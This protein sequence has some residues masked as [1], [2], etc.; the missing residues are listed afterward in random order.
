MCLLVNPATDLVVLEGDS[1]HGSP[2][3]FLALAVLPLFQSIDL[4]LDAHRV[5]AI[6]LILAILVAQLCLERVGTPA[7]AN[8][9]TSA[10][11]SATLPIV[12]IVGR[13][14]PHIATPTLRMGGRRD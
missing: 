11:P 7:R 3:A 14:V 13:R 6:Y 10:I 5:P 2:I 9:P 4:T 1:L 12:S 8:S